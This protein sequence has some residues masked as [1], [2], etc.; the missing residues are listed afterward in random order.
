MFP[1]KIGSFATKQAIA[2]GNSNKQQVN[3]LPEFGEQGLVNKVW[4]LRWEQWN[5]NEKDQECERLTEKTRAGPVFA[6][7]FRVS[8]G[9]ELLV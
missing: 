9:V 3:R 1:I 7:G 4:S 6:S 8:G 2:D 5:S